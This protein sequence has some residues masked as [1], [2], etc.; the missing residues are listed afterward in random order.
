MKFKSALPA[1]LATLLAGAAF[2]QTP[3]PATTPPA[4]AGPPAPPPYVTPQPGQPVDNNPPGSPGQKPAW[5]N[6]TRAPYTPSR[7]RY[8][9]K[10]LVDGLENPWGLAFLPDGRMLVTERAGR[11]RIISDGKLSAPLDGV[12]PVHIQQISGLQDIVVDPHFAANHLIYWTFVEPRSAT[13]ALSGVAVAR[14]RLVDGEQPRVEDVTII[15]RQKPDLITQ[16]SN[17]GGRMLFD[18][19]GSLFVT[20]GDRDGDAENRHL[21][22]DLSTGIGKI[23]RI[24]TDGAAAKGDPFVSKAGA[25][26]EIWASGFRNPLGITFRPGTKELWATD[27][28]PRGGDELDRIKK[29]GDYGWPVIN[30][31]KEYTGKQI[32]E[33]TAK[34]G[35]QQPAYYWDPVISPSSVTFYD[36]AKFPEWK[37]D[38]FV[39]SLTQRHLARLILKGDKVVGE[40]RLLTD[41]NER[42]REVKEAPDGSILLLTDSV[43]GRILQLV[44]AE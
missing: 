11:I 15:Y 14:G 1:L 19:D 21:I 43:T 39:T 36:G 38:A 13:T 9:V 8:V 2:A 37:G 16:H 29:G 4:A 35:M 22:Q 32:G 10:T 33:G 5:V 24:T 6:Q 30:Y 17:Y 25:A 23:V 28:G 26:P 40:E 34:K 27:V 3:A 7:T 44:P 42:L 20:L 31:G 12:P 18:R 41:L